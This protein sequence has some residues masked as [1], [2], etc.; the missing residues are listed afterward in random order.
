MINSM[1]GLH[2]SSVSEHLL[3]IHITDSINTFHCG[4]KVLVDSDAFT[5][6]KFK[7]CIRKVILYARLTT[8]G[9]EDDISLNA[10]RMA[11]FIL[12]KHFTVGNLLHGALHMEG[13]T[14]LLHL[15]TQAFGN[16]AVEGGKALFQELD[17]CHFSAKA[18][19]HTGE[20]HADD[21]STNDAEVLGQGVEVQE[22]CGIHHLR[23]I[24]SLNGQPFGLGASGD[25][26][27]GSCIVVNSMRINKHTFLAHQCDIRMSED[28]LDTCAELW[29]DS[30]HT[31]TSLREGGAMYIGLCGDTTHIQACTANIVAF[32]DNY[33]Q[34]LFG[35][36]F[37]G[38]VTSRPRADD[39]E[40]RCCH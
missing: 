4:L 20:L 31:F 17:D 6:I 34:T 40:I 11:L 1:N 7:S 15:L 13:D 12:E 35:G 38:A 37:S 21:T 28:T 22:A 25:D 5:F 29:H 39:D 27:V 3:T 19:E 16:V 9:H 10:F 26:D 8:C 18:T 14:L 23:I 2:L 33:L 30:C 32:E 36:I 24:F